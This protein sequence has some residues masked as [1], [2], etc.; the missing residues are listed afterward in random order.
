MALTKMPSQ[1]RCEPVAK[2]TPS[3]ISAGAAR[4]AAAKPVTPRDVASLSRNSA[5]DNA[6]SSAAGSNATTGP[7][8]RMR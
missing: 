7:M 6:P 5:I 1:S 2:G 4:I 8:R 3:G